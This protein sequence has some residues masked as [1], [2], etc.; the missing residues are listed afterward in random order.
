MT[1][2][3]QPAD[4]AG[5]DAPA[6]QAHLRHLVGEEAEFA[7]HPSKQIY[8]PLAPA[9][10]GEA[11]AE[12]SLPRLKPL[13]HN[14]AQKLFGAA[15]GELAREAYDY[16]LLDAEHAEGFDLLVEGLQQGR[17]GLGVQHGARVRVEGYDGRHRRGGARTFDHAPDDE[18]V[19]EVQPVE[20][21]E[22][23]HRRPRYLRV[24]VS[25]EKTHKRARMKAEG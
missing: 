11:A 23:Q 12:I 10:E 14:V 8:V 18:L 15:R 19:A 25:V 21:A 5:A 4:A 13:V 16:R 6:A 9:P 7:A 3:T 2:G 1:V 24:L 22:R 20:H 17:R